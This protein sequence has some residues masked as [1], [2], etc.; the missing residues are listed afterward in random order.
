MNRRSIL[1]L[2]AALPFVPLSALT[3]PCCNDGWVTIQETARYSHYVACK[4]AKGKALYPMMQ[5]TYSTEDISDD[6]TEERRK[7]VKE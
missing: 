7:Y 5:M 1:K 2:L 3:R 4:C 6:S